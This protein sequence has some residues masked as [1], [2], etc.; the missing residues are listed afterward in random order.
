MVARW[1]NA[2]RGSL[3]KKD[4]SLL[5]S[6]RTRERRGLVWTC[7]APSLEVAP[8]ERCGAGPAAHVLQ[9]EHA[10]AQLLLSWFCC[11]L[12]VEH[13]AKQEGCLVGPHVPLPDDV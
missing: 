7:L 4:V 6:A 8:S 1:G 10:S 13:L 5:M 9:E 3:T 2:C 12:E 11:W